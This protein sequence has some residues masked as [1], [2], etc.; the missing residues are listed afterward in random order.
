MLWA[1][2]LNLVRGEDSLVRALWAGEAFVWQIYPQHDDAHHSKLYAFLDWLE[3][4]PTLRR[5]HAC[6]NGIAGTESAPLQLPDAKTLAEWR[7]CTQ[8]A[9]ARLLAQDDL[10]TQLL[11]FVQEKR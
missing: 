7:A 5:F 4:P 6:W 9:R 2:D 10:V 3:A 8:A 1:C 11:R